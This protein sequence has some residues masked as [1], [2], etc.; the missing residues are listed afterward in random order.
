[1]GGF[2]AGDAAFQEFNLAVVIGFV[3]GNVEPFG[4]IVGGEVA[5]GLGA[6]VVLDEMRFVGRMILLRKGTGEW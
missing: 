1:V 5:I 3:F 4:V 6:C 2:G